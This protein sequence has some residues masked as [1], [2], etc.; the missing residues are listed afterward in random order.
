MS[1]NLLSHISGKSKVWAIDAQME[2]LTDSIWAELC[3]KESEFFNLSEDELTIQIA[4]KVVNIKD[5][6][7]LFHEGFSYK[8]K[9]C[10]IFRGEFMELDVKTEEVVHC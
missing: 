1:L 5:H 4:C 6:L 3:C 10:G 9:I 8:S 2:I 7:S